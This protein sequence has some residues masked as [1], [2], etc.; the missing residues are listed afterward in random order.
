MGTIAFRNYRYPVCR[1]DPV[2]GIIEHGAV[3][4]ELATLGS[5]RAL[6][7]EHEIGSSEAGK[8]A[9]IITIDLSRSTSLFPLSPEAFFSILALNGA[10][11]EARDVLVDGVF[12]RRNDAFTRH[13]EEAI[14]ARAREWCAKFEGYYRA[15]VRAGRPMFQLVA[16]E[17]QPLVG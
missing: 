7:L 12:V 10:G 13:D 3:P 15:C 2:R 5:A 4:F 8:R 16:E 11:A 9:D 1:T 14:V 17:F 6:G